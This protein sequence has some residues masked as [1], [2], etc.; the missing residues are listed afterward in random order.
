MATLQELNTFANGTV[1]FTD[2]RP[3]DVIFNFPTAV[4]LTDQSITT[5]TF[6]LQRTIDI[7]EII[8][9][10]QTLITFEIDVS[11]ISGTTVAFGSLPAGVTV[12]SSGGVFTV[13]GIDSVSDWEAVRAPTITLPRSDHQGA[14]EYTCTIS[15]TNDGSRRNQQWSVGTFKTVAVL[16]STSTLSCAIERPIR[17]FSAHPIMAIRVNEADFEKVILARFSVDVTAGAIFDPSTT[18]TAQSTLT[19][20]ATKYGGFGT[21][22]QYVNPQAGAFSSNN[23]FGRYIRAR[24]NEQDNR[25]NSS[26]FAPGWTGFITN[27]GYT[28]IGGYAVM[29]ANDETGYSSLV[30]DFNQFP[31]N[32]TLGEYGVYTKYW[33]AVNNSTVNGPG[34]YRLDGGDGELSG[35][36]FT[37]NPTSTNVTLS[38]F[39]GWSSND[40]FDVNGGYLGGKQSGQNKAYIYDVNYSQQRLDSKHTITVSGATIGNVLVSQNYIAIGQSG[41]TLVYGMSSGTLERTISGITCSGVIYDDILYNLDGK[42]V[43]LSTGNTLTTI[44][45]SGATITFVTVSERYIAYAHKGNNVYLYDREYYD[46]IKTIASSTS[47]NASSL[48]AEQIAIVDDE[49]GGPNHTLWIGDGGVDYYDS[50]SGITYTNVGA[51][52]QYDS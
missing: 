28:N 22:T 51:V 23:Q 36:V 40:N 11:A 18:I 7:I 12:T 25:I 6:T 5:Q 29:T 17:G 45:I 47:T 15:Y 41:N 49:D 14:F 38:N 4:N 46:H 33:A 37:F 20:V 34:V 39:S 8:Q 13:S 48:W 24:S 35:S 43:D 52:N 26:P 42:V 27:S 44:T 16:S 19:A 1:T 21:V 32:A 10:T 50:G 31:S 3:S 2:S 30:P 9:P